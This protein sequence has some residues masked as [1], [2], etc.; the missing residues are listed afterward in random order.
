MDVFAYKSEYYKE[1]AS[2][3]D[4]HKDWDAIPESLLP[5]TGLVVRDCDT[6]LCAGFLY[7]DCSSPVCMLEWIVANPENPPRTSIK[8]LKVLLNGFTEYADNEEKV[9]F[10]T[11]RQPKLAGL[12]EKSGFAIG[13]TNMTNMTRIPN[14]R[15]N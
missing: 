7:V 12:Y 4:V 6:L 13:D 8:A 3:W 10:T 2:W 9:L 15:S 11:L 14:G 5:T 1:I